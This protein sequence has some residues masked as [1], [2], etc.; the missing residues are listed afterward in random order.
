[1]GRG[2]SPP[3]DDLR[4]IGSGLAA[5][6]AVLVILMLVCSGSMIADAAE[7][8]P[9]GNGG[10]VGCLLADGLNPGGGDAPSSVLGWAGELGNTRAL[11]ACFASQGAPP[12]G[13]PWW[14]DFT[15]LA[16]TLVAAGGLFLL[17]RLLKALRRRVVPLAAVDPDDEIGAALEQ[18]LHPASECRGP[19][20]ED[21]E[22]GYIHLQAYMRTVRPARAT[23][24]SILP[25]S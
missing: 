13:P 1:M 8:W 18:P 4:G 7:S 24:A 2:K 22:G 9:S 3:S 25:D 12:A 11:N 10:W 6:F 19:G 17:L 16:L 21:R 20:T 5:R 14:L 23:G 15:W